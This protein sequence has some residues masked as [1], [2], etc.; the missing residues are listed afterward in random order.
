MIQACEVE[1][2]TVLEHSPHSPEAEVFRQLARR[3]LDNDARVIPRPVEEV[4]ELEV[5][6]RQHIVRE[7][8]PQTV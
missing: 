5:L 4:E 2:K 7:S 6:Y 3:V 8:K 1:G